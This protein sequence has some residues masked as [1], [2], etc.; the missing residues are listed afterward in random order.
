[1]IYAGGKEIS[2]FD[3]DTDK[4]IEN[5]L[6]QLVHEKYIHSRFQYLKVHLGEKVGKLMVERGFEPD[7][8]IVEILIKAKDIAMV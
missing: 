3:I 5:Q 8:E 7:S 6:R 2:K 1:M 4:P